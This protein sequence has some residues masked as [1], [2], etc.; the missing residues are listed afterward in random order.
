MSLTDRLKELI[1]KSGL[2]LPAF[3]E[4]VG[5]SRTTLVSYRDGRT[6][7]SIEFLEKVCEEFSINRKWLLLGEGEP[8][9]APDTNK[10]NTQDKNIPVETAEYSDDHILTIDLTDYPEVYQKLLQTAEEE[11]RTPELQVRY[12]L[13]QLTEGGKKPIPEQY[14]VNKVD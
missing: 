3:S 8:H 10:Q 5:V 4:R 1:R 13:R 2:S 11:D 7:P 14:R 12:I 6:S 9:Q